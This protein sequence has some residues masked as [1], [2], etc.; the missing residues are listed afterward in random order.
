MF[1]PGHKEARYLQPSMHLDDNVSESLCSL[2]ENVWEA[3]GQ[4]VVTKV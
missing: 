3:L 2:L 4:A 1:L